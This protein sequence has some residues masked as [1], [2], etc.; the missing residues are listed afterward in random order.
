MFRPE[1]G[2]YLASL[3]WETAER[4]A[5]PY[6][7]KIMRRDPD[8]R[9]HLFASSLQAGQNL[10]GFTSERMIITNIRHSYSSG[11]YHEPDGTIYAIRYRG[12]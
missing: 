10:L 12:D 11:D 3:Y 5:L 7:D 2:G 6:T 4:E 9:E 1:H 8:G